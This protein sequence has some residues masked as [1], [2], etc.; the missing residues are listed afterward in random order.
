MLST[1]DMKTRTSIIYA[2]AIVFFIFGMPFLAEPIYKTIFRTPSHYVDITIIDLQKTY[3]AG[4]N[5]DLKLNLDGSDY[6]GEVLEVSI[7][8]QNGAIVWQSEPWAPFE[9]RF[10]DGQY[11]SGVSLS[12]TGK[13]VV[14][15]ETGVYTIMASFGDA[16]LT[17]EIQIV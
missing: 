16:I 2:S 3:Q 11:S 14:I 5:I 7:K 4:Q 6:R 1:T 17:R 9:G 8:D 15:Y 10:I 12:T 13:S